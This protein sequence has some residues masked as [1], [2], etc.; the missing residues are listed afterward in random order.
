VILCNLSLRVDPVS[1]CLFTQQLTELLNTTLKT[2]VCG[3]FHP[4]GQ[5]YGDSPPPFFFF[6]ARKSSS[7]ISSYSVLHIVLFIALPS[8]WSLQLSFSSPLYFLW[9]VN[10][11]SVCAYGI[12]V[13]QCTYLPDPAVDLV[14]NIYMNNKCTS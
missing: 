10:P 5:S 2:L 12:S 8:P 9:S 13:P 3:N 7:Y 11:I 1:K 14:Y 4:H 6:S